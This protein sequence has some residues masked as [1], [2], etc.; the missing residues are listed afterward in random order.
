VRVLQKEHF[1]KPDHLR[2]ILDVTNALVA[3]LDLRELMKTVSAVVRKVLD[4][5]FCTVVIHE[6]DAKMIR[7]IGGDFASSQNHGDFDRATSDDADDPAC[8]AIR[9]RKSF[10]LNHTNLERM[11]RG[12]VSSMLVSEGIQ[13]G[14][15]VPLIYHGNVLGALNC[16]RSEKRDFTSDEVNLLLNIAPQVAMAIQNA[17]AFKEIAE[18]RDKL[19][20]EKHYLEEEIRTNYNVDAIIGESAQLKRVLQQVELVA[21]TD[22]TVLI[23]GE[24]GTGKELIA[25]A[26]HDSSRRQQRTLVTLNCAAIPTGLLESELFGHE[27]GAFTGAVSRKLGRLEV[28]HQGTL[29]LDEIG[30]LPLELQ[31]KLLRVLQERQFERLGSTRSSRVDKPVIA[32]TNSDPK[33]L[34]ADHYFRSDLYYRLNVFPIVIPPLRERPKDIPL[35]IRYFAHKYAKQMRRPIQSISGDTMRTLCR[36]PWPGNVRELENLMERAVILSSGPE[37]SVPL[38]ELEAEMKWLAPI[39]TDVDPNKRNS[40]VVTMEALEREHIVRA[41]R[42]TNGMIGGSRGAAELLG[43][44]R[45]TLSSR[46]QRLG[47]SVKRLAE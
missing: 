37:L 15:S 47:I 8:I 24:T 22:S 20:S 13:T 16:A 35:L 40:G 46:M 42:S 26:I 2:T 14:C 21:P 36:L 43:L 33:K 9:T 3:K 39:G 41:L 30:D 6:P 44:N 1:R 32:A 34:V 19:T 25:R 10:L 45:T 28:A 17:L 27:R 7:W 31:P 38:V 29:F 4:A 23:L 12:E 5:K 11:P 18:L